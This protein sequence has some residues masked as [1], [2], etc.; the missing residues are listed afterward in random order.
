[1]TNLNIWLKVGDWIIYLS[2]NFIFHPFEHVCYFQLIMHVNK[3]YAKF[4]KKGI[5]LEFEAKLDKV[6]KETLATVL[7]AYALTSSMPLPSSLN[8]RD[9]DQ[10]LEES[11]DFDFTQH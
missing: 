9:N 7:H 1:M 5:P 3:E 4:W 8:E 6:F 2:A 11:G 10:N